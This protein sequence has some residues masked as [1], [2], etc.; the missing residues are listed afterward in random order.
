MFVCY[1]AV[2]LLTCVIS[3]GQSEVVIDLLVLVPWPNPREFTGRAGGLGL[4]PGARIAAQHINNRSDLLQG[5][6]INI[7]EAGHEACGLTEQY[8]GLLNVVYFGI[9][10]FRN[11]NVAA[12]LGLYC[13]TITASLSAVAGRE[14]VELLQL[15]SANSP[16]LQNI[17]QYPH[18]WRFLQSASVYVDMMIRL[19]D[20]YGWNR[21]AIIGS[22]RNIYHSGIALFL[23]NN[24]I[25]TNKTIVYYGELADLR[26]DV[27]DQVLSGLVELQARLVFVTAETQQIVSLLCSAYEKGMLYPHYLWI[28][29]DESIDNLLS[30]TTCGDSLLESLEASVLATF[31]VSIANRSKILQP[32]NISYNDFQEKH[33]REIENVEAEYAQLLAETNSSVP[34]SPE[35]SA[36]IYDQ[37]WAFSIAFNKSLPELTSRGI[38]V[39]D[40]MAT[41]I[42][43]EQLKSVNFNGTSGSISFN[44]LREV[45]TPIDVFQVINGVSVDVARRI[46]FGGNSS[47]HS[48]INL[49]LVSEFDDKLPR[50]KIFLHVGIVVV[51][52]CLTVCL[53]I[54]LS[55]VL[56][57]MMMYRSEHEIKAVSPTL[58]LLMFIGCYVS[59]VSLVMITIIGSVDI[60][61]KVGLYLCGALSITEINSWT[62]IF[63][64][65]FLKLTRMYKIFH[66]KHMQKLGIRYENWAIILQVIAI[67]VTPNILY[68]ILTVTF[69]G[70]ASF[71]TEEVVT[72]VD[73]VSMIYQYSHCNG[74]TKIT[75]NIFIVTFLTFLA[76]LG[77]INIY[78]ASK[79]TKVPLKD[80]KNTR[81]VNILV[82]LIFTT[83]TIAFLTY[84]FLFTSGSIALYNNVIEYITVFLVI[85]YCL[86]LLFIPSVSVVLKRKYFSTFSLRK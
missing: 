7:I 38:A 65:L 59:I 49:T 1:V 69:K 26:T 86:L 32:L 8:L 45:R 67:T 18:L 5:Y 35:Y 33:D 48:I 60:S 74:R 64:T 12:V 54:L 82:V 13:S 23:V 4:L 47:D 6:R 55:F 75:D 81:L 78:L 2:L 17:D 11:R 53:F 19:M 63:V 43:E 83:V 57:M 46:E 42:I 84:Y 31:N 77:I 79:I 39:H 80:F 66:N 61:D 72:V 50:V 44:N 30:Q 76:C 21:L 25:E 27:R 70:T 20:Q 56:A 40:R 14:E 58:S 9:N 36:N 34:Y 3:L 16:I 29:P 37:V 52:V 85:M 22:E 68:V 24:S 41:R 62:I 71:A 10:P 51:M 15:S 73:S 28:I